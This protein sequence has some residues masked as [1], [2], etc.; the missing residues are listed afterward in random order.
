MIRKHLTLSVTL[1]HV[2]LLMLFSTSSSPK[3]LE[4]KKPIKVQTIKLLPM[5]ILTPVITTAK[6]QKAEE[7]ETKVHK[8]APKVE[9]EK[10]KVQKVNTTQ[11]KITPQQSHSKELLKKIDKTLTKVEKKAPI[12]QKPTSKKTTEKAT[13]KKSTK[14]VAPKKSTNEAIV[15]L[16]PKVGEL[17]EN[18]F[19]TNYLTGVVDI[20]KMNLTLPEKGRVK[21]TI[22]VQ[23]NG[24]IDTIKVISSESDLNLDYLIKVLPV[25]NLPPFQKP[26]D[27]AFTITFCDDL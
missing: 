8:E 15:S 26:N 27:I 24:K 21:V 17:Q 4:V 10:P 13:K 19:L 16:S 12:Q 14:E 23:P 25:I 11:K 9:T 22:T 20:F 5:P 2:S 3:P 6:E 1:I 7:K 18:T